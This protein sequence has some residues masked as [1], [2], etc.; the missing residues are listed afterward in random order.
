MGEALQQAQLVAGE[1]DALTE[2]LVG[3]EHGADLAEFGRIFGRIADAH[4]RRM[5]RLGLSA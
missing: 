5:E 2:L 3:G 4:T 1:S